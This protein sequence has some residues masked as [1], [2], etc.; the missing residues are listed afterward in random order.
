M[1]TNTVFFVVFLSMSLYMKY[2]KL[3]DS[4]DALQRC[5]GVETFHKIEM[6]YKLL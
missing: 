4:W 6:F 2:L 5:G 1:I 3:S